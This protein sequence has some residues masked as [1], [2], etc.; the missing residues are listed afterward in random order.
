VIFYHDLI[1]FG[2]DFGD[3]RA[4]ARRSRPIGKSARLAVRFCRAGDAEKGAK[5]RCLAEATD[6]QEEGA[7]RFLVL[8]M[9]K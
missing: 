5:A 2:T 1:E 4:F 9:R 8:L 6:D 3:L 7:G